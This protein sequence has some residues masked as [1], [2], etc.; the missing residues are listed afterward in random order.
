MQD[1]LSHLIERTIH[2]NDTGK[3]LYILNQIDS[4]ARE[5]NPEDVIAAWQRALGERGL[6]AGRFYAIYNPQASLP[7]EDEVDRRKVAVRVLG[8]LG[9]AEGLPLLWELGTSFG[10]TGRT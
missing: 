3:F 1:T 4:T 6:T 10:S 5:N 7:I 2:R 8:H 9:S